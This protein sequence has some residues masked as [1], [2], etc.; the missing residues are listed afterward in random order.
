MVDKTKFLDIITTSS[1]FVDG[2]VREV[3]V[4]IAEQNIVA[5]GDMIVY[6]WVLVAQITDTPEMQTGKWV[7]YI[8][9]WKEEGRI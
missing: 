6:P 2:E 8:A 5:P 9:K 3:E 1:A 4:V 7:E